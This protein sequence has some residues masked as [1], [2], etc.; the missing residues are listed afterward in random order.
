GGKH[1][2][3]QLL[4]A[5]ST[6]YRARGRPANYRSDAAQSLR[7]RSFRGR[8]RR[9]NPGYRGGS[10]GSKRAIIWAHFTRYSQRTGS[11]ISG[12]PGVLDGSSVPTRKGLFVRRLRRPGRRAPSESAWR[13]WFDV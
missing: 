12:N 3:V 2:W 5:K 7:G 13:N 1:D 8:Q 10:R 6:I 4:P 11:Q 9:R